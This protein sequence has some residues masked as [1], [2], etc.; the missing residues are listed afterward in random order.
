MKS[1]L[2][3]IAFCV[4]FHDRSQLY[5]LKIK[6]NRR[7]LLTK[8]VAIS[9]TVSSAQDVTDKKWEDSCIQELVLR[10][11]LWKVTFGSSFC[12]DYAWKKSFVLA[13]C[14]VWGVIFSANRSKLWHLKLDFTFAITEEGSST[15]TAYKKHHLH[16][17]KTV[18]GILCLAYGAG[19]V[20]DA[21]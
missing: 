21:T 5:F 20:F 12:T 19:K 3:S 7:V 16:V 2:F 11:L 10:H 17:F 15:N 9:G 13:N 18:I 6:S 4:P 14:S 8:S 1:I